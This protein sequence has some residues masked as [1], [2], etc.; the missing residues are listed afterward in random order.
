MVHSG[1]LSWAIFPLFASISW[2]I[3]IDKALQPLVYRQNVPV[4]TGASTSASSTSALLTSIVPSTSNFN[5]PTP[6]ST[7]PSIDSQ[8]TFLASTPSSSQ[9]AVATSQA[10]S[11]T[12]QAPVTVTSSKPELSLESSSSTSSDASVRSGTTSI[13]SSSRTGSVTQQIK[14]TIVSVSGSSTLSS[15]QTSSRIVAAASA[16]SSAAPGLNGNG[17]NSSSSSSLSTSSKKIV[18]GVVGGIGGAILLGGLAVVAWRIWGR[19]RRTNYEEDDPMN[20]HPASSGHEKSS[21]S[22]RAHSPFRSTLDQYH[23]P[24]QPV[25]TASNF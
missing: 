22:D 5:T 8:T 13:S 14:T 9:L 16:S 1:I 25:N 10:S 20:P 4:G 24:A 17:G 19:S 7:P 12:T 3:D 2:A 23:S 6:V 15:V 18:G 11:Q 21:S